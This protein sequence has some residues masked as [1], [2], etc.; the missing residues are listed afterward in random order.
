MYQVIHIHPDAP[1]KPAPGEPCNGCGVCCTA[2]PCPIGAIVSGRRDGRCAALTWSDVDDRYRCGLVADPAAHLPEVL[3][4]A[5]PLIGR[6]VR[7]FIS[8]G[9]G[10]DC[11]LRVDAH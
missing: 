7:R 4:V 1:A 10:C 9:S 8:A 11:S 2:E 3:H 6:V 5:A